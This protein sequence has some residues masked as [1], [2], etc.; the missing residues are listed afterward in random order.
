[1]FLFNR[2][3]NVCFTGDNFIFSEE[4]FVFLEENFILFR[5]NYILFR[6]NFFFLDII[7]FSLG[8]IIFSQEE[9][10]E[11]VW[12]KTLGSANCSEQ[13]ICV[14]RFSDQQI[15]ELENF[16]VKM[17]RIQ[18]FVRS[19]IFWEKFCCW[20]G[21]NFFFFFEWFNLRLLYIFLSLKSILFVRWEL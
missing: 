8:R 15:W 18:Y 16:G 10:Y 5:D 2:Q 21:Q 9:I 6:E 19:E 7:L 3:K 20:P 14:Q 17:L 1:M 12:F 13:K 11:Y 4:H